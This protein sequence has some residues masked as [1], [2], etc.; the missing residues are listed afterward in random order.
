MTR[1]GSG[2]AG[3]ARWQRS[4]RWTVLAWGFGACFATSTAA[5]EPSV[6]AA[7]GAS[8]PETIV[9]QIVLNRAKKGEY[10]VAVID[11]HFLARTQDL[12][13]MGVP[14]AGGRT[15]T[16]GGEEYVWVNSIPGLQAA[17]DEARLSLELVAD[18]RLLPATTVDF[19]TGHSPK[20]TYPDNVSGFLNYDIGYGGGNGGLRDGV[21]G[22]GELGVRAGDFL[23]LGEAACAS[24][25][26]SSTCVRLNTSL[27]HDSRDTLVRTI[28]GDFGFA[29]NS[30]GSTLQMGGLSYSKL[31]DIDP[32]FIRYPQQN[33]VGTLPTASEVDVYIDGQRVR[34]LR[35]PAGAFDLRNVTQATGYRSVDLVIRDAFGREQRVTTSF[36]SSERSLKQGLHEYSYNVGWLRESFG[37]ESNDYGP[38]VFA[39]FHRY[40]VSDTLTL[41]VRAEG[42]SGFVSAGPSATIVLGSAG[43]LNLAA[44]ASEYDGRTGGAALA[45][46]SYVGQ[47]W[48]A[49]AFARKDTQHYVT[50]NDLSSLQRPVPYDPT[51]NAT[52]VRR[53]WEAAANVGYTSARL[54][55]LSV[56]YYALD[57]YQGQD[58]KA[59][60][61]SYGRPLLDGRASFFVTVVNE[62][63]QDRRTD[64]FAGFQYNFDVSHYLT[65]Y[66]QRLRSGTS[67][68]LQFQQAQPVGEGL[69][70]TIGVSR[71]DGDSGSTTSI[72]PSFQY[73][74]RWAEIRGYAQQSN[75]DGSQRSYAV[76]VAGG[77]AWAGGMVAAGRP[78]TDAFGVVKVDDL[79][80]V[81]VLVN[82]TEIGRTGPDGRLFVPSLSSFNENQIS[83][84]V[85]NVPMDFVFPESMRVVSPAYRAGAV[86]DFHARQLQAFVGTLRIR[87]GDKVRPAEFFDVTLEAGAKPV[88]FVTGRGGEFYVEDLAPGR[89]AGRMSANGTRCRFVLEVR[90]RQGPLTDLG[91]TTCDEEESPGESA[92]AARPPP[93]LRP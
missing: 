61:L 51:Y 64:V 3:R 55:S 76:A 42:K 87:S 70:Y 17:F 24:S 23:F 69:G 59:A 2:R 62:R 90:A 92:G 8:A 35:L 54:G 30:L 49:A 77:I 7:L 10:F 26:P 47:H 86:V 16:S 18:P 11:G 65:G 40:G 44:S 88:T 58:R 79:E 83:I 43:L 85:A 13:A 82:N 28:V 21:F 1:A 37:V 39:G 56:G 67:E 45:S 75:A 31:Y 63:A 14:S 22:T 19:W 48:N 36:Y 38:P 71:F 52:Y 50:V 27:V 12:R 15:V 93:A 53:N 6:V 41:G 57:A 5:Q 68:S 81:R 60:S 72:A 46:Y 89:Y 66:F 78:V 33:L 91:E 73:N 80:G 25:S 20:V 29:T 4:A 34:T 84:D 9:V 32:Y 74:G